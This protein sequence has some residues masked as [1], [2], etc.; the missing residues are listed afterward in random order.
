MDYFPLDKVP[1][2]LDAPKGAINMFVFGS[3]VES[4]VADFFVLSQ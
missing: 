2:R 4:E 3:W 1:V